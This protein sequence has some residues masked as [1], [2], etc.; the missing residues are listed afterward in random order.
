M[1]SSTP[2]Q[3]TPAEDPDDRGGLKIETTVADYIRRRRRRWVV[4]FFRT[5]F[6]V[7]TALLF[8]ALLTTKHISKAQPKFV[9]LMISDGMGPAS[10]SLAR[11][12]QRVVQNASDDTQ[13]PL[14]PYLVG[15]LRTHSAGALPRPS[16]NSLHVTNSCYR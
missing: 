5:R 4:S 9:I 7:L 11:T 10:L 6:I 13:L 8:L 14:D 2:Y 1:N 12:F 15:S 16:S 3:P